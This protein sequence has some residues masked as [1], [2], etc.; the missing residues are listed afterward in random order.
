M[1]KEI[2]LNQSGR[3]RQR[4]RCLWFLVGLFVAGCLYVLPGPAGGENYRSIQEGVVVFG[5]LVW[6][7]K[8][9]Y[10]TFFYDRYRP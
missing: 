2:L 8:A 6:L 1:R 3:Q 4:P 7:G 10:D 5:C 9:L